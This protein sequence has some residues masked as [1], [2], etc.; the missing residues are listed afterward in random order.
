[1]TKL[2]YAG[3]TYTR[4][5]LD[6]IHEESQQQALPFDLLLA[7]ALGE[8]ELN[9]WAEAV[10]TDPPPGQQPE[11]SY[12]VFQINTLAHGGDK[13][14]W[15]GVEG[16]RRAMRLMAVR[17]AQAFVDVGGW[18]GWQTDRQ[19][20]LFG[21]WPRAQGSIYPTAERVRL[22]EGRAALLAQYYLELRINDLI[23]ALDLARGEKV[24]NQDTLD[25]IIALE[26]SRN[27]LHRTDER[28]EVRL[29]A[30]E[31]GLSDLKLY[32]AGNDDLAGIQQTNAQ[33][34]AR[35]EERLAGIEDDM[36]D[37]APSPRAFFARFASRKFLLAAFG[38]P[39]AVLAA[40]LGVEAEVLAGGI[41]VLV[42]GILGIAYED[43]AREKAAK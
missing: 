34:I 24:V 2:T 18:P 42:A 40:K 23:D 22:C 31:D 32:A 3:D 17:W 7:L 38:A 26:Q 36:G 13:D 15:C 21:F 4:E 20:V 25:R 33:A 16:T 30:L 27:A 9:E 43:A 12:G 10:V 37:D 1:M 14:R 6:V 11:A 8:S 28:V 5:V 39:L 19:A 35:I 29:R 41:A